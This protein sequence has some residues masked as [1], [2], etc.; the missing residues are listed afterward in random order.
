MALK[1]NSPCKFAKLCYQTKAVNKKTS[2]SCSSC[3]KQKQEC[4]VGVEVD[5]FFNKLGINCNSNRKSQ[6]NYINNLLTWYS[7]ALTKRFIV[8]Y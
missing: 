3:K 4:E 1:N 7:V 5:N 8:R 6:I 2:L